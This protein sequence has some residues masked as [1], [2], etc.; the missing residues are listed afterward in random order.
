MELAADLT[1][2]DTELRAFCRKYGIRSLRLIGSAARNELRVDSDIDLLDEFE[3]GR[4]P[5]GLLGVAKVELELEEL[6]GREV[7][8]RSAGDLS[9][10]LRDDVVAAA[11]VVYDA[12]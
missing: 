7:N 9:P 4:T 2:D 5:P 8:F 10:Y 3:L 11:R 6:L 1:V 12:A